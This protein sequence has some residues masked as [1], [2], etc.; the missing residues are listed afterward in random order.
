M[1]E[2]APVT[3]CRSRSHR[4]GTPATWLWA[5]G[6]GTVIALCDSCNLEWFANAIRA[7]DLTPVWIAQIPPTID[8]DPV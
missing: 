6:T 3:L 5:T 4:A 1:V 8:T 2:A 7:A